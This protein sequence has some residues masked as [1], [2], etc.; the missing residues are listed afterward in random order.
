MAIKPAHHV[1][2]TNMDKFCSNDDENNAYIYS[3]LPPTHLHKHG[4]RAR[5][6]M[7]TCRISLWINMW[8]V[9]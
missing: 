4:V 8:E 9:S 3:T 5:A 7:H 6:H 2:V 1:F